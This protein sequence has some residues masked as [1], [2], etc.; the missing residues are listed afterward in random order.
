MQVIHTT[1]ILPILFLNKAYLH[2]SV[3]SIVRMLKRV[4]LNETL[5]INTQCGLVIPEQIQ[6][7]GSEK[8]MK[9]RRQIWYGMEKI[10]KRFFFFGFPFREVMRTQK[11]RMKR[12]KI[13]LEKPRK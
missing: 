6:G 1:R 8:K 7:E 5:Y 12:I 13:E 9:R 2:N 3:S 11:Q 4:D 10:N